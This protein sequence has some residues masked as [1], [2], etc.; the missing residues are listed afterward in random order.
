MKL[1]IQGDS[2]RVRLTRTEVADLAAGKPVMQTTSF[3]PTASLLSLIA[4]S[5]QAAAPLATFDSGRLVI[6]LP[7]ERTRCWAESDEVSI[8]AVQPIDDHPSLTLF[9]E[10]DFEC[11]HHRAE[12]VDAFPNPRARHAE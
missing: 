5:P 9:I 12:N 11:L 7:Q 8:Q 2:I 4:A 3:S 10:K 6:T 1:R